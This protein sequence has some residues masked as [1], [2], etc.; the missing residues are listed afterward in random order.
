MSKASVKAEDI[1]DAKVAMLN[2][3]D[4]VNKCI[5]DLTHLEAPEPGRRRSNA[6]LRQWPVSGLLQCAWISG[7][8]A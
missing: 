1:E 7:M 4:V 8:N 5:E 6:L 2:I 3:L